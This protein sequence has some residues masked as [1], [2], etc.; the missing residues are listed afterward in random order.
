[1]QMN[2]SVGPST[3]DTAGQRGRTAARSSLKVATSRAAG[4]GASVCCS[5]VLVLRGS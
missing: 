3:V 4:I 1:M 2:G 5:G